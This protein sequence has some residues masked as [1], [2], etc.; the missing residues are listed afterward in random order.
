MI[1]LDVT[2]ESA[3]W[4]YSGLRVVVL[5]PGDEYQQATGG[6]E[7]V[8]VPLSGSATVTTGSD[9]A[10]LAGRA[11]VFDGPTD[12]VYVPIE[13][14]LTLRSPDGGRF[15]LATARATRRLPFRHIPVAQQRIE[16][17]GAGVCS[18][19][20]NNFAT[21]DV[22]DADRIIACEVLTPGG[23]WSSYPPHR[24]DDLEEIYYF[25]VAGGGPAYQRA[26]GVREVRTG[27]VV[28]IPDGWHGPSMA[29]PGHDLYYLNVMAGP[30]ERAWV[31]EDE[32]EHAWIRD[33]WTGQEIDPRLPFGKEEDR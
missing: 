27:E 32:P 29:T 5:A 13:T 12:V 22:L 25:E 31:I 33:T 23:N 21:T 4:G 2:P 8:V 14:T 30:G 15:A 9:K 18:R 24:H 16:L 7:V 26:D 3:G 20:V 10:E 28:L 6:D 1:R 17:R 11:S 19:Q